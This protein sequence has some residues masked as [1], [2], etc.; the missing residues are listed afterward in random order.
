[1]ALVA[2]ADWR[3]GLEFDPSP[4]RPRCEPALCGAFA[5]KAILVRMMPLGKQRLFSLHSKGLHIDGPMQKPIEPPPKV[6]YAFQILSK[7]PDGNVANPKANG[8]PLPSEALR[9]VGLMCLAETLG[10]TGFA[11][12]PAFLALLRDT[13]AISNSEAGF[14]GGAYFAGY[15]TAV[16][17]LSALTDRIDA[18]RI[19]IG[20]CLLAAVSNLC[21][22]FLSQG[23]FT[24]ALFQAMAGAGL[25]GTYMPGLK[26]LT[27]RV[28]GPRQS[29]YISF[30]TA[31]F[32]VGTS[33][34]LLLAGW[35]GRMVSWH[36][37]F[38][39]L[40]AGPLIAG[41]IIFL[42]LQPLPP[43]C[44]GTA[45]PGLLRSF[46][47]LRNRTVLGYVLR[48][49]VHC[50]ELFGLRSWMVAFIL[51]AYGLTR[52][53]HPLLG[54]TEAAALI[55]FLGIPV[56]ILGNETAMRLGRTRYIPWAMMAS[57]VLAWVAGFSSAWPWWLMLLLLAL[58]FIA[59][60]SDSA[61]LT[62]GLVEVTALNARGAAMAVYSFGGFGAGFLAPLVFGAVLD[63][64]GG[65]TDPSAWGLAFGSLGIGCLI[66]SIIARLK[67]NSR[68]V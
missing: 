50:F 61:A 57:G 64:A 44:S 48:Y 21:F 56:S 59:I 16:P 7:F 22:A 19:Y 14:I 36:S 35:L 52:S 34:S 26:A 12:Y 4:G 32:G 29:R 60:M 33:L 9:I 62:A 55:N 15:M 11:A 5:Y 24:A 58:Y 53:G 30:Y 6:I 20:S 17:F 66:A 28:T 25:G 13:W 41:C 40:A 27:D 67:S 54:A 3:S 37:A 65:K 63:V 47:V 49:A 10:M 1:M 39:L 31:T 2:A 46:S 45:R 43:P 8:S 18:R 68:Q 38:G 42:G 51:F 23:V